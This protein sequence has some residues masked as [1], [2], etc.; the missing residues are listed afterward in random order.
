[1]FALEL[2]AAYG[3]FAVVDLHAFKRPVEFHNEPVAEILR[4]SAAVACGISY[5]G[6]LLGDNFDV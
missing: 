6:L 1:M 2:V 5:N 3:V 4:N